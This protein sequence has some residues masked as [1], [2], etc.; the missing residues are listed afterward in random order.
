MA[1]SH[2]TELLAAMQ[3][4]YCGHF[5]TLAMLGASQQLIASGHRLESVL[6]SCDYMHSTTTDASQILFTCKVLMQIHCV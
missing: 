4:L 6:D 3:S 2:L 1:C 5:A